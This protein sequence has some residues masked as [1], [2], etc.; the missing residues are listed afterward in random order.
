MDFNADFVVEKI[1]W[2]VL[3]DG[4]FT[5]VYKIFIIDWRLAWHWK[6]RF[7]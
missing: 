1:V 7:R 3:K 5:G 4:D 2:K 6:I